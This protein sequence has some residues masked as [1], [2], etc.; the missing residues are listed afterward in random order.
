MTAMEHGSAVPDPPPYVTLLRSLGD[1]QVIAQKT[2]LVAVVRVRF[3][4]PYPRKT[5]FLASLALHQWLNSPRIAKTADYGPRWR[6]QESHD[7]VGLQSDR[8]PATTGPL[9]PRFSR[10]LHGGCLGRALVVPQ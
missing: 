7:V 6:G 8:R 10:K 4:G 9:I 1:V 3:A 2:R 5:G